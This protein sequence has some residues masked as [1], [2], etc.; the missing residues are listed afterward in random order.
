MGTFL[1]SFDISRF[2]SVG[3]GSKVVIAGE[4]KWEELRACS[5]V[6][7][8]YGADDVATGTVGVFGPTHMAYDRAIGTVRFVA[9]LMT[10]LV[11]ENY[12]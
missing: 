11:V 8:R 6:L 3:D 2:A 7:A 4:G 5:M 10:D 9:A 1:K 12:A